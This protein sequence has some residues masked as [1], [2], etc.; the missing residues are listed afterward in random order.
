MERGQDNPILRT[1]SAVIKKID[2]KLLKFIE[3]MKETMELE[4]GVGLAAPQVGVNLRVV[5]CKFNYDTPHELVVGMIN[6]VIMNKSAIMD[7]NEEGCLSL[8]KRF[9]AIARHSAVTVKF[10]DVKGRQQILKLK[11]FNARV[12]Q[13]EVD[14]VDAHLYIDH[15][16]DPETIRLKMEE[17]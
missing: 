9:D 1:P 8:P 4:H 12:V 11:N 17:K 7:L 14:H 2:K 5:V 3:D 16:N 6:P 15:I 10:L 13:H